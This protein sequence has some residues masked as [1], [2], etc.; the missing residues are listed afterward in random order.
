MSPDTED[1]MVKTIDIPEKNLP[2]KNTE[3]DS[4][5]KHKEYE[6]PEKAVTLEAGDDDK[7]LK[8]QG[9]IIHNT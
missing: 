9:R 7:H 1:L 6:P 3:R 8:T 4:V 5:L 2:E